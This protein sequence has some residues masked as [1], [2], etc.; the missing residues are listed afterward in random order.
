[1]I[2]ICGDEVMAILS[3]IPVLSFCFKCFFKKGGN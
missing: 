1:M 2:H 3:A